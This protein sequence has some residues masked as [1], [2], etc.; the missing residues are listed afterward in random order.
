MASRE[1]EK[2]LREGAPVGAGSVHR[3]GER[4]ASRA[5]VRQE[6]RRP[7][8][9]RAGI[10]TCILAAILTVM[11]PPGAYAGRT[12]QMRLR[13]S[14]IE[15]RF[16]SGTAIEIPDGE[17]R[18]AETLRFPDGTDTAI[19]PG[20][21]FEM[22]PGVSLIFYGRLEAKGDA[23]KPIEFFSRPSF[24]LS[25]R[26]GVGELGEVSLALLLK[27]V[28]PANMAE[29]FAETLK[30]FLKR[31]WGFLKAE[32]GGLALSGGGADGSTLR[33]VIVSGASVPFYLD[34]DLTAGRRIYHGGLSIRGCRAELD[35]VFFF[36]NHADALSVVDGEVTARNCVFWKNRS[37]CVNIERS[38][39]LVETSV[40]YRCGSD[41]IDCGNADVGIAGNH[42]MGSGHSGIEIGQ[43]SSVVLRGNVILDSRLAGIDISDESVVSMTGNQV[44]GR[45]TG[46]HFSVRSPRAYSWSGRIETLTGN[47][48]AGNR[49]EWV[50][51]PTVRGKR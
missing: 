1:F 27:A 41:G 13:Q 43:R 11:V 14:D 16:R 9:K 40:F 48:V 26:D 20:A 25:F 3:R 31:R 22:A 4:D 39:G 15:N 37:D 38:R 32:W 35:S 34:R 23:A 51:D 42:I 17:Y 46:V 45:G 36:D 2:R 10:C 44:V 33:F 12:G 7:I 18:V 19:W 24:V 29:P 28:L 30:R 5:M 50:L 6:G 8:S 21:R 47:T 49:V